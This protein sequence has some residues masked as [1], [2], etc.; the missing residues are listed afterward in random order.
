[1]SKAP[2]GPCAQS[3]PSDLLPIGRMAALNC[4]SEK[5]LHLYQRRGIVEPRYV[6]PRTGY[7]YYG[8]DQCSTLDA[9][10]QLKALG[11]SLSDIEYLLR[12]STVGE[13]RERIA[14]RR[15]DIGRR[16]RE[17]EM[18]DCLAQHLLGSCDA[19]EA[20]ILYGEIMLER[21]P[22]RAAL[23]ISVPP[24]GPDD[25]GNVRWE[26]AV[27]TAKRELVD[28]GFSLALFQN[29]S[30][31]VRE[32]EL[33]ERT[34]VTRE[35]L[36]FLSDELAD[37]LRD[38]LPVET[39]PG[40]QYLTMYY[41]SAL[42]PDGRSPEYA[43]ILRMLDYAAEKGFELAG[44]YIGETLASTPLFGFEGRDAAFKMCLP[45]CRAVG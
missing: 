2:A 33:R 11:F 12:E 13:L 21:L 30:G 14:A 28:R 19:V 37:L 22:D 45:V 27:R 36:I 39:V 1:M 32:A 24:V 4:V 7:R 9:V 26:Q 42:G 25:V 10:S 43:G 35:A 34:L 8:V 40:G 16:R 31:I 17:L 41:P 5:T 20:P 3:D 29:V 6:D 18:A 23:F 44:D 38:Q 15:Q